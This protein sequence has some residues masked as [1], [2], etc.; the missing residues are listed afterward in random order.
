MNESKGPGFLGA[1]FL[2]A[3]LLPLAWPHL[4]RAYGWAALW[5]SRVLIAPLPNN[6]ETLAVSAFLWD[7]EILTPAE[8]NLTLGYLGGRYAPLTILLTVVLTVMV[9]RRDPGQRYKFNHDMWSLLKVSSKHFPCLAP[10]A[11]TGPITKMDNFS[12]P[13]AMARTPLQF[14]LENALLFDPYGEPYKPEEVMNYQ[15]GLPKMDNPA[16]GAD[17]RLDADK[18]RTLLIDQLG[19]PFDGRINKLPGYRR[20]LAAAFLAHALDQK[21]QAMD[22]FNA[23]SQSWNPKT[24]EVDP[25]AADKVLA[26]LKPELVKIPLLSHLSY[27]N[28]YFMALLEL[29]RV[30]GALP[31]S[32]WIWLK[33]TDRL[34]FY[35]LNQVGGTVAWVEAAGPFGHFEAEKRAETSL[36]SPAVE[37]ALA[38]VEKALIEDGYLPQA[39]P[40][41]LTKPN[42]DNALLTQNEPQAQEAKEKCPE[43]SSNFKVTLSNFFPDLPYP[44]QVLSDKI[45]AE[46]DYSQEDPDE[47]LYDVGNYDDDEDDDDYD[48]ED[49]EDDYEPDDE[50][51]DD[52]DLLGQAEAAQAA[53]DLAEQ[54]AFERDQ[55]QKAQLAQ[56]AQAPEP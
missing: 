3:M 5:G 12:G 41:G 46:T 34:L 50:P 51:D 29:A 26:N 14:V 19:Y 18:L 15:T 13:W 31:S 54:E 47:L 44:I 1:I 49:G 52:Q 11:K 45:Q 35:V 32:L 33:P 23:L 56:L 48:S 42:L 40:I 28:V 4:G 37:A 39:Q 38:A 17:N 7:R 20:A 27:E 25:G 22:I 36:A 53:L 21:T 30:K 10:I 6:R 24:L 2:L 16:L 43:V 9:Y 8:A 55:A